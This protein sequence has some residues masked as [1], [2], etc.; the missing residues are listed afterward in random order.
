MCRCDQGRDSALEV[1]G[2][3]VLQVP[4]PVAP[5]VGWGVPGD[6]TYV[7]PDDPE[8]GPSGKP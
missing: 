5:G 4:E 3:Y 6:G 2:S 8:D 1:E 7:V